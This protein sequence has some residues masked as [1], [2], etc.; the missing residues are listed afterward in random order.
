MAAD[1]RP[2]RPRRHGFATVRMVYGVAIVI[3]AFLYLVLPIR[4]SGLAEIIWNVALGVWVAPVLFMAARDGLQPTMWR[5]VWTTRSGRVLVISAVVMLVAILCVPMAIVL[6]GQR[7]GPAT[8]ALFVLA[9]IA[10]SVVCI[11]APFMRLLEL[12]DDQVRRYRLRHGTNAT[13]TGTDGGASV[14]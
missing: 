5:E 11:V 6:T 7:A 14:E 2:T 3:A 4:L 13:S 1:E 8:I 10:M 12:G 9:G